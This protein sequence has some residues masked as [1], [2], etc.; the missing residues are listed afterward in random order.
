MYIYLPFSVEGNDLKKITDPTRN[1]L[2]KIDI[3]FWEW[4][5]TVKLRDKGCEYVNKASEERHCHIHV[6]TRHTVH[7]DCRWDFVHK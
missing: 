5:P 1:L 2:H 4:V 7:I 6:T 3:C